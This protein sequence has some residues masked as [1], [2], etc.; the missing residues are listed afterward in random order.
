MLDLIPS[1]PPST[2]RKPL[3]AFLGHVVEAPGH[4]AADEEPGSRLLVAAVLQRRLWVGHGQLQADEEV[5]GQQLRGQGSNQA[6]EVAGRHR[7][8]TLSEGLRQ[9]LDLGELPLGR[10]E[11]VDELVRLVRQ[12]QVPL[13]GP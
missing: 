4:P 9:R 2:P 12:D 7:I 5:F 11:D 6:V 1:R 13:E 8:G 3:T 10:L